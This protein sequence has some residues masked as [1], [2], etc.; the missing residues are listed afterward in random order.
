M[1]RD[2]ARGIAR[3]L[4]ALFHQESVLVTEDVIDGRFIN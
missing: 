4:C 3:D 1:S 2:N